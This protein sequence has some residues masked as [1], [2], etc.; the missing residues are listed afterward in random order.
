MGKKQNEIQKTGL[1]RVLLS[2]FYRKKFLES[3]TEVSDIDAV[4]E[5]SL[6]PL[7]KLAAAASTTLI[8]LWVFFVFVPHSR[9][10]FLLSA[11]SLWHLFLLLLCESSEPGSVPDETK[12]PEEARK[13]QK[14]EEALHAS[15]LRVPRHPLWTPNMSADELNASET[16]VFLTWRHSLA[17]WVLW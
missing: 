8:S 3:F 1:G 13:Q 5:Q 12:T 10:H 2:R 9:A 15:N 16:Q 6:E 11:I 17:R 14:Q 4:V 7:P